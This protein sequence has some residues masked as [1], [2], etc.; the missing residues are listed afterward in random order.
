VDVCDD[1][2]ELADRLRH[3]QRLL[4][5]S[6]E[7]DLVPALSQDGVDQHGDEGLVLHDQDPGRGGL[8]PGLGRV[9]EGHVG[10]HGLGALGYATEGPGR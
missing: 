4:A 1:R 9:A 7:E 2:G 3:G 10:R 8:R 6:G 5:I